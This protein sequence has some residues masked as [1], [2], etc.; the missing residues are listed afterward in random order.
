MFLGLGYLR[1]RLNS[2]QKM[3]FR[4]PRQAVYT[5]AGQVLSTISETM[6]RRRRPLTPTERQ[7][8]WRAK[9]RKA[10]IEA[11]LRPRRRPRPKTA[12]EIKRAYRARLKAKRGIKPYTGNDEWYTPAEF[13]ERVR[14]VLGEID[15]DPASNAQAQ[16]IVGAKQYFTKI[17]D[18]LAQDW[19]GRVWLNPPYSRGLLVRFVNKMG[20]EIEAGN[21]S[22]AIMLLNNFTDADWFQLAGSIST[23]ICFPRG[24]ICFENAS[25]KVKDRPLN[26]QVFFYYG[27]KV[28]LFRSEFSVLGLTVALTPR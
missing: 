9:K 26:G 19:R 18:A 11:G 2:R 20:R 13:V 7:R 17:N 23:A 25:G 27:R 1:K 8:R 21:V 28:D 16:Q 12:A 24:R 10:E 3:R 14:R 15:L 6:A 4:A 22:A 5:L